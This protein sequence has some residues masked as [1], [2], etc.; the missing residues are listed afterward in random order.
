MRCSVC[1]KIKKYGLRPCLKTFI[2]L[3]FIPASKT[4]WAVHT[5]IIPTSPFPLRSSSGL[6]VFAG[7]PNENLVRNIPPDYDAA[8]LLMIPENETWD[9]LIEEVWGRRAER[10]TRYAIKREPGVFND[11]LLNEF[12]DR[13]PDG[14]SLHMI[15]EHIYQL[16]RQEDW[17][18]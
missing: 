17:S 11:F 13:L 7:K 6:S 12:I 2:S 5:Q 15:D 14:Y 3:W 9:S 16:S 10:F 4:E 1:A 8:Q 18:L